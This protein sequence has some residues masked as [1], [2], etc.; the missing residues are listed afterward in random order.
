[1]AKREAFGKHL[2]N[3]ENIV[4]GPSTA[5]PK[6]GVAVIADGLVESDGNGEIFAIAPND[7]AF[8][9]YNPNQADVNIDVTN[10][11]N[12]GWNE[13][14]YTTSTAEDYFEGSVPWHYVRVRVTDPSPLPS[15][16]EGVTVKVSV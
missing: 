4:Q 1:M 11:P 6:W 9:V 16:Y 13:G 2:N 12:L 10:D 3:A 7:L 14:Y 15:P 5:Q 8:Q